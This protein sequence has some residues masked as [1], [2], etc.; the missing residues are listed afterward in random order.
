VFVLECRQL[1]S[2][3]VENSLPL[4]GAI[5]YREYFRKRN[6]LAGKPIV[7]AFRLADSLDIAGCAFVPNAWSEVEE[8]LAKGNGSTL[9]DEIELSDFVRPLFR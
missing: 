6:C 3:M 7:E 2:W 9:W 5:G 8:A 4:K 1:M